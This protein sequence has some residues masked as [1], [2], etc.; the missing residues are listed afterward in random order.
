MVIDFWHRKVAEAYLTKERLTCL[1]SSQIATSF[2]ILPFCWSELQFKNNCNIQLNSFHLFLRL[3]TA[4]QTN[5]SQAP[6]QQ[7]A[8]KII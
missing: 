7:Y 5:Y 6:E 2:G 4:K 3:A 1:C 8:I